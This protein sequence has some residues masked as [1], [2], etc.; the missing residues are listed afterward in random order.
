MAVWKI[1]PGEHASDWPE[2]RRRGCIGLGWLTES[3]YRNFNSEAA[4]L[5]RLEKHGKGTPGYSGGAARMIWRFVHEV[6]RSDV[7]VANDRYSRVVGIGV[8]QGDYL[9]RRTGQP[10]AR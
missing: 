3:N 9:L 2:Y 1:A 7:V 8:V 10:H 4:I 6:R 5:R